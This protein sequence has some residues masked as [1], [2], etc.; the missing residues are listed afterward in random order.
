MRERFFDNGLLWFDAR[1]EVLGKLIVAPPARCIKGQSKIENAKE[2]NDTVRCGVIAKNRKGPK[3][4]A[5]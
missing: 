3:K 1:K 4:K 5:G 2:Q